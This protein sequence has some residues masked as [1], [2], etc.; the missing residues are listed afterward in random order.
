MWS[1]SV[2]PLLQL[3]SC[4]LGYIYIG[5]WSASF[6]VWIIS[7]EFLRCCDITLE[8]RANSHFND[9]LGAG[10]LIALHLV[11]TNVVFAIFGVAKFGHCNYGVMCVKKLGM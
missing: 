11:K 10:L 8:Q 6:T 5:H 4:R 3:L 9:G 7:E 2:Y 1:V